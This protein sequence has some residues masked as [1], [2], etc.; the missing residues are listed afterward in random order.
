LEEVKGMGGLADGLN[1]EE[2]KRLKKI[3]RTEEDIYEQEISEI[4]R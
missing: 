4:K 1:E 2:I 3:H